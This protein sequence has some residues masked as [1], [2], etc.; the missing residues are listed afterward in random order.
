[1]VEKSN[2][3]NDGLPPEKKVG[4]GTCSEMCI[5]QLSDGRLAEDWLINGK[6]VV[7]CKRNGGVYPVRWK[8]KTSTH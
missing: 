4:Q 5:V 2:E 6:W 7:H 1:M 3:W 8:W